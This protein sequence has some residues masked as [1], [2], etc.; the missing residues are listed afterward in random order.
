ERLADAWADKRKTATTVKLTRKCPAWLALAADRS[1]YLVIEE[2]AAL[3]RR[4]FALAEGLGVGQ[5]AGVMHRECPQGM[6]G[7]GWNPAEVRRLLRSRAVLGEF[8]P[9]AGTAGKKGR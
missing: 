4:V 5:I 2:K 3:V 8:Q 1:A 9:H 6:T 7:K